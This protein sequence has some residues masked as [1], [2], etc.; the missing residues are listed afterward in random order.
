VI[1]LEIYTLSTFCSGEAAILLGFL[2]CF[3]L[4]AYMKSEASYCWSRRPSAV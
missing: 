1:L 3:L 2:N 4:R